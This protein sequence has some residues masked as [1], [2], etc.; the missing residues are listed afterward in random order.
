[1]NTPK[2]PR[3]GWAAA[4]LCVLG[5]L[6]ARLDPVGIEI[7]YWVLSPALIPSFVLAVA[8]GRDGLGLTARSL[9]RWSAVIT[10]G[11]GVTLWSL[12]SLPAGALSGVDLLGLLAV[13]WSEELS[14]RVALLLV[15][16]RGLSRLGRWA[17]PGAVA[18]SALGFASM[19]GHLAQHGGALGLVIF[20]LVAVMF[21]IPVVLDRA[22][23]S[24]IVAHLAI[25]A[26]M[27]ALERGVVSDLS[28][29]FTRELIAGSIVLTWFLLT[30]RTRKTA[31]PAALAV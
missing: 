16:W 6:A 28:V 11:L 30:R 2:L 1:M 31:S 7:G 13:A 21:A 23:L 22:V 29:T 25:D 15:A 5:D 18:V 9:R 17:L 26:A 24:S 4:W 27:F 3:W 20:G 19:P 14:F 12:L 10:V 8:L